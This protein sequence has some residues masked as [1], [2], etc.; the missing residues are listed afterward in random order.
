MTWSDLSID[1]INMFLWGWPLPLFLFVIGLTISCM[2]NF[3][4]FRC[5]LTSWKYVLFPKKEEGTSAETL[6]PIQAFF[7][8][9]G[10]V[11]GNGSLVGMA[12]AMYT[13]GPGGAFWLLIF[14]LLAMP[15]RFAEVLASSV[16]TV[17]TEHG[18][19]GG[20]MVY[21]ARVPG[22]RFLPYVF[23]ALCL[24]Y[25]LVA[26][27]MM[28]SNSM[29]G[30]IANVTGVNNWVIAAIILLFLGY[31]MFGGAKRVV[32]FAESVAPIKVILFVIATGSVIIY[33][34]P[35]LF[36]ALGLMI[37]GAFSIH[38]IAGGLAGHAM[39]NALRLGISRVINASETGLGSSSVMFGATGG[40]NPVESS[41]M[42]MA[43][44]FIIEMIC[45]FIMLAF[46]MAGT[47]NSGDMGMPMVIATYSTVF[48]SLGAW[49]ATTL[50]VLFGVGTLVGYAFIGRECWFF[51]TKGRWE[52]MFMII[53]CIMAPVGV[54]SNVGFVWGM[55]D[56]VVAGLTICNLY[57]IFY[58]LPEMRR[59]WRELQA[60]KLS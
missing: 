40:K 33:F 19:R 20:P 56:L 42:S 5:F 32:A 41:I 13:G 46:T 35:Q 53:Y 36:V 38:A 39:Q 1:A 51:L 8:T 52:W 34:L 23:S 57:G 14:G 3:V 37:K 55:V 7:T 45:F 44:V 50:S 18:K 15:I 4:Q 26:A 49:V 60:N 21:L 43:L 17:D 2:F 16:F 22:G 9:L 27:S 58:L 11:L 30:G 47:W 29:A 28:Q 59:K 31:I 24:M 25:C 54:L 48:G 10:A 6:T 12:T